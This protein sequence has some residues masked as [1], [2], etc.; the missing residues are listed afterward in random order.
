MSNKGVVKL[1]ILVLTMTRE[2]V[3]RES[4]AFITGTTVSTDFVDT[5]S[6]YSMAFG[7]TCG[8]FVAI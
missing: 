5:F 3:H 2:S 1:V 6:G 7:V 8:A 4:V